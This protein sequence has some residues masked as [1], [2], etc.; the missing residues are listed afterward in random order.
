[1]KGK[2]QDK[3]YCDMSADKRRGKSPE[4]VMKDS[5]SKAGSNE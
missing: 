2:K 4:Q 3:S 1:M 5:Y